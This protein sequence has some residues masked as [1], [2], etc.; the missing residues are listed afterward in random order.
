VAV[1]LPTISIAGLL[2]LTATLAC[3]MAAFELI[4]RASTWYAWEVEAILAVVPFFNILVIGLSLFGR[5]VS[6]HGEARPFLVGFVATGAI[7]LAAVLIAQLGFGDQMYSYRFWAERHL[8]AFWH[9][10]IEWTGRFTLEYAES[11]RVGFDLMAFTV[12]LLLTAL[13]GGWCTNRAGLTVVRGPGSATRPR[14]MPVRR[15]QAVIVVMAVVLGAG[16]WAARV[17]G[18]WLE[19][20][21]Y[22]AQQQSGPLESQARE[23]YSRLLAEIREQDQNPSLTVN[24]AALAERAENTRRFLGWLIARRRVYESTSRIMWFLLPPRVPQMGG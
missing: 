21:G 4:R 2:L 20:R 13:M 7:A 22:E 19:W 14:A 9:E 17:R 15:A 11:I 10:Y 12:P 16:I 1:R 6:L 3:D 5:Q 8:W 18:R 23:T 24:R